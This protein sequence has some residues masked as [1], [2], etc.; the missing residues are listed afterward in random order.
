MNIWVEQIS[1]RHGVHTRTRFDTF[2][3]RVGRSYACHFLVDSAEAAEHFEI[4]IGADGRPVARAL[5]ETTLALEG[6]PGSQREICLDAD[7]MIRLGPWLIRVRTDRDLLE[8]VTA[9]E[10]LTH[11]QRIRRFGIAALPALLAIGLN[12]LDKWLNATDGDYLIDVLTSGFWQGLI[13]VAWVAA[14]ALIA[15]ALH[16][17]SRLNRLLRVAG[18]GM[19]GVALVHTSLP[20]LLAS[21][22]AGTGER[23]AGF[24]VPFILSLSVLV[25]FYAM[26]RRHPLSRAHAALGILIAAAIG[27]VSGYQDYRGD[28]VQ[29]TPQLARLLPASAMMAP[30]QDRAEVLKSLAGMEKALAAS[31]NAEIPD[32]LRD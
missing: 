4:D 24:G 16:H 6:H 30:V 21:L 32:E 3:V 5:G 17:D 28:A 10:S 20:L 13:V 8:P 9:S 25:S 2:P 26:L 18:C 11:S 14:T 12:A 22:N 7:S 23:L 15:F 1:E 27:A 19:L 29:A 31:R